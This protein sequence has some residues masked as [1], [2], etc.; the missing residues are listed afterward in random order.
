MLSAAIDIGTNSVRLLVGEVLESGIREVVRDLSST[1][2]GEGAGTG[3]LQ[4]PSMERTAQAV[5]G[6]A[7]RAVQ[8]GAGHIT[9]AATSAVRQAV[10][11]EEFLFLV[12]EKTGLSVRVLSGREEAFLTYRGVVSGLFIDPGT[13]LVLDVGGGS[14]EFIWLCKGGLCAFSVEM[15]AVRLAEQGR[16]GLEKLPERLS[17]VLQKIRQSG[18]IA[19]AVAVGG[20]ATS[21]AA[22]DM[23]L[24]IYKPELVHGYRLSAPRIY[25]LLAELK[26][27]SCEERQKVPGLM[28]ERAD[29]IV[30]GTCIIAE[31]LKG[32]GLKG[33]TVSECDLLHGLLLEDSN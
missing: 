12:K 32:L 13:T 25:E 21:L 9:A 17:L 33:I 28:P 23:G 3:Y 7:R 27:K 29:I 14:T 26:A 16:L 19:E 24:K 4:R 22:V 6:F 2:L 11:R 15:G 1:R 18:N 5:A 31:V 20:T 10:N 30:T 8:L